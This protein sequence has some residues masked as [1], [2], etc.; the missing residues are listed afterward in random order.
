MQPEAMAN[1]IISQ[2][3]DGAMAIRADGKMFTE[4]SIGMAL[5]TRDLMSSLRETGEITG[6][7]RPF[8]NRDRSQFLNAL[9]VMV[10]AAK[11]DND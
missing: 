2:S 6:G 9:E 1:T 5:A 4:D 3:W 8:S 11:R 10:Q 7:P